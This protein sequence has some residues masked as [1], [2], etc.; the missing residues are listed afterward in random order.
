MVLQK[1][2]KPEEGRPRGTLKR[3]PF[4]QTR[5]GFMLRYEMPVVYCLLRQ[6]C[7]GRPFE[8]DWRVVE[9]V[10]RGSKDP[11]AGKPKFRRYLAEYAGQG[12]YC[13]RGKRLTSERKVYYEGMRRRKT[14]EY[15]RRNRRTLL[16]GMKETP[17]GETLLQEIRNIL[18]TRI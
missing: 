17:K 8:P 3:F 4:E 9:T 14:E 12:V 13:R 10:C 6:L 7:P 2:R 15:V 18:K 11:S 5:L 1:S 16:Y